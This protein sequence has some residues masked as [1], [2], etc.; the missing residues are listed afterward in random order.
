MLFD[1]R[2]GLVIV[3]YKDHRG[4]FG[5][6]KFEICIFGVLV[7]AVVLYY[8]GL[9]NKRCILRFF[10]NFI[11]LGPVFFARFFS[12]VTLL[13]IIIIFRLHFVEKISFWEGFC[14]V[15]L[16]ENYFGVFL[17]LADQCF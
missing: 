6:E 13:F 17:L 9:L 2:G 11:F 3:T 7:A 10:F 16:F 15:L 1:P 5:S 8:L 4:T 14:R 12:K